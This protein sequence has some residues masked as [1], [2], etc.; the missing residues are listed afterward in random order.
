MLYEVITL[1]ESDGILIGTPTINADAPKPVWDL[2]SCMMLL[3]KRGKTGGAFGSYGWSGEA[4]EM[5]LH[6]LKSL[7]FKVPPL[8]PMK[9][10][11]IPTQEELKQS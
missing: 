3:E 9:I 11:L 2:L 10:K 4:V 6:R 7:N 5:I 1:E 8:E